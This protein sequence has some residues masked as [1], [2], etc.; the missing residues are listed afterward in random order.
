MNTLREFQKKGVEYAL[1]KKRTFICDEMGLGKTIE[2]LMAIDTA[3]AYPALIVCPASLR[4]NWQNEIQKWLPNK[5]IIINGKN[6]DINAGDFV[7][8]SYDGTKKLIAAAGSTI[9]AKY[10]FNSIV[11]D[12]SHYIKNYKAQRTINATVLAKKVELRLCLSG[13]PLINRPSEL[14]SQLKI[15]G[16]LNDFGGFWKFAFKYCRA[17]KSKWGWDFSGASN[18][19]ELNQKLRATCYIRRLKSDVLQELPAKQRTILNIELQNRDDYEKA[20]NNL[21]AWLKENATKDKKFL[22]AIKHLPEEKQKIEKSDRAQN[23]IQRALRAEQLVRIEKLKQLAAEGKLE[24]VKEWIENFNDS[25]KL[26]VFTTHQ[27][28]AQELAKHF[29]APMIIG[30]LSDAQ[31]QAAV[32]KFQND[33]SCKLIVCNIKAGGVGF[34][35]TAAS[36]VAFL[37]LGWTSAEHDQAEDRCHRIGQTDSVNCWY[38]LAQNTIEDKIFALLQKK[39]EI[40]SKVTDG[41]SYQNKSVFKELLTYLT[42]E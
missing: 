31:K 6:D 9:A 3:N 28:I 16:R 22:E 1:D 33:E 25:N 4:L 8:T 27:H 36:N 15:L 26:V 32:D 37:E 11:F 23:T 24:E 14:L 12:E 42:K 17:Y 34:T 38:L 30:G 35:L 18:L 13:T 19:E 2:A 20:K 5:K 7:I 40:V 29:K 39:R 41:K 21:I 10:L